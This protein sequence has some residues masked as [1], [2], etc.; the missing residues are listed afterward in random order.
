MN[1]VVTGGAGFLGTQIIQ[2]LLKRQDAG[3]SPIEF[4]QITAI[5][6]REAVVQDPRVTS[7]I[8]DISQRDLYRHAI[9]QDTVGVF[10]LAAVMSG[11][12][13]ENFDLAF[14]INVDATRNLLEALRES[15][16]QARV[17]F[18][19]SLAVFGGELPDVVTDT[20]ATQPQ[21]TYGAVKAIGE[22]LVNEY[23]RKGFVDGRICRVPTIAIRP[24]QPNTAASSFVSGII[25]EPLKGIKTTLPT[26][27]DLK[28]W[29][30]SPDAAVRNLVEVFYLSPQRLPQWRAINL[31][32][33]TVTPKEMLATLAEQAGEETRSLVHQELDQ[34]VI[35]IVGS[36]P[37]SFDTSTAQ[38]L[39][40]VGDAGFEEI[41]SNY[42][43]SASG[44]DPI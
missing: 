44:E 17:V 20:Y 1:I 28:L 3:R 24:G 23:S 27:L 37:Q 31:P 39:G 7:V 29:I 26:P 11:G 9:T 2:E 34:Q 36:W 6:M 13:E 43:T 35:D 12:S 16:S 4:T 38:Q 8:G 15:G 18:T 21:S 25:R 10:H 32:G 14:D 19:S 30:S 42:V 33:V 41:Y 22:L 40:L 5:D